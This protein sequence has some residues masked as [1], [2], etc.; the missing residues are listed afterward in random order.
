MTRHEVA[1]R[2]GRIL[3][4]D[5]LLT[6]GRRTMA[7][8]THLPFDHQLVQMGRVGQGMRARRASEDRARRAFYAAYRAA[9]FAHRMGG[10][11]VT[12]TRILVKVEATR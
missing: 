3:A 5:G 12:I 4:M 10:L 8:F 7:G 6:L 11:E 2:L 9:R 1:R